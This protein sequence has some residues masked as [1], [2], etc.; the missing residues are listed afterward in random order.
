VVSAP[1]TSAIFFQADTVKGFKFWDETGLLA[2]SYVGRFQSIDFRPDFRP[3]SLIA[4]S[5]TD[6]A[7]PILELRINVQN[8]W[9]SIRPTLSWPTVRQEIVRM[10]DYISRAISVTQFSRLGLRIN[11]LWS[12][13]SLEQVINIQRSRI[14]RVQD[15][16][17]VGEVTGGEF[18]VNLKSDRLT[19][20][21]AINAVQNVQT[22]FATRMPG[23]ILEPPVPDTSRPDYALMLDIDLVDSSPSDSINV[24]PH[25][26][27]AIHLLDDKVVPYISNLIMGEL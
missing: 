5:P 12:G 6:P 20:R 26:N 14:L 10:V 2:N 7:D 23:Q 13:E 18:V 3:P 16:G 25:L 9:L 19:A 1:T 8:I 27:R 17:A 21:V 4:L 22:L 11:L 15:W 24:N